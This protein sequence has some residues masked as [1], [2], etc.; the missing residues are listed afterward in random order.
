MYIKDIIEILKEKEQA[1]EFKIFEN[2]LQEKISTLVIDSNSVINNCLFFCKGKNFKKEYIIEANK[3]SNILF[4]SEENYYKDLEKQN[5]NSNNSNNNKEINNISY[6]I[7]EDIKKT[8]A[9][10]SKIYYNNPEEKIKLIGITGT[11]GKTTTTIFLNNILNEYTSKKTAY[12]STIH[13]YTKATNKPSLLTTPES[14]D[15]FRY[16]HEAY[17][18]NLE[19]LTMEIASQGY[20]MDRVYGINFNIGVF[21][22]ISEDHISINEHPNFEDYLDSKIKLLQNSDICVINNDTDYF[23]TIT[24]SL[25]N[26]QIITFGLSDKSDYQ[27]TNI[28]HL[29]KGYEFYIKNKELGY[30]QSFNIQMEGEFNILNAAAAIVVAKILK[31]EDRYIEKAVKRTEILGRMTTFKYKNIDIIIDYAHNKI[32][33]EKVFD[34]IKENYKTEEI[35]TIFGCPGDK[36]YNRR[37]NL[38]EVASKSSQKIFL[39]EDDPGYENLE[40]I[41][42]DMLSYIDDSNEKLILKTVNDRKNAIQIAINEA[43]KEDKNVVLAILGKGAEKTQKRKGKA[44]EYEGDIEI[45]KSIINKI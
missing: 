8:M 19:Y 11:K 28:R 5:N 29:K 32:S 40:D 16:F 22:N 21:L 4:I 7:V 25:E 41:F 1:K 14:V 6:I 44:E 36:A 17:I 38:T 34:L 2:I 13:T 23:N 39:T 30:I 42:K 43:L 15:V 33:F 10:I 9:I 26:K 24:K 12:I 20:K 45:V 27:I 3:K 35:Y 31:I 37:K 18:N